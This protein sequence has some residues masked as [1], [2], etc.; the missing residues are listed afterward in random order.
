MCVEESHHLEGDAIKLQIRKHRLQLLRAW[1][2]HFISSLDYYIMECV[3]ESAHIRLDNLLL[4]TCHFG[5][6]VEFHNEY[7]NSVYSQC[8]QQPSAAYLRDAINEV[9]NIK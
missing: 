2:I 3:L 6:I 5:E 7:I 1:L 8:L 9:F 4:K